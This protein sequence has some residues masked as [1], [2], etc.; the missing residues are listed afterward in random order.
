MLGLL[1]DYNYCSGCRSCE[2]ACQQ[3]HGYEP[4]R[5][6]LSLTSIGPIALPNG[7]WQLDNLPLH[8]PYCNRCARR[9]AKGKLPACVHHC[10]SGC[11]E[12]G[13][14]AELAEKMTSDKMALFTL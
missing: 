10:Q 8:A 9:T 7:K 12:I 13:E 14:L 5:R 1:I 11:I 3:E 2:V 4:G 6:G